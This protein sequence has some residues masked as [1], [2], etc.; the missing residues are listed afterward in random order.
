MRHR[1]SN[2]KLGMKLSQRIALLRSL[3]RALI[4]YGRIRTTL[5]R[6]KALSKQ[7]DGIIV[8]AKNGDL[9]ARRKALSEI[10]DKDL[11][12]G[13]FETAKEKFADKKSGFA[14]VV[15]IEPR[16]GDNAQMALVYFKEIE[17]V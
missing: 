3:M 9:S 2:K 15:K 7:I 4:K 1:K 13:L 12:N 5:S 14:H 8:L 10:P 11:I 6:A 16:P 17:V